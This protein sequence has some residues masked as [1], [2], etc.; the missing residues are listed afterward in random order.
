MTEFKV[1]NRVRLTGPLVGVTDRQNEIYP[2]GSQ[3][4]IESFDGG[5]DDTIGNVIVVFDDG[6]RYFVRRDRMALVHPVQS[7]LRPVVQRKLSTDDF[8]L[9]ERKVL[10]RPRRALCP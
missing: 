7:S 3:G 9:P 1:G 2:V 4:E 10:T 6:E 8:A 5:D